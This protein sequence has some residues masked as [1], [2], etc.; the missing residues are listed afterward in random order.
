MPEPGSSTEGNSNPVRQ[1][2]LRRGGQGFG[3]NIVGPSPGESGT[4]RGVFISRLVPTGAAAQSG[5]LM[6]GDQLLAVDGVNVVDFTHSDTA[7][8]LKVRKKTKEEEEGGG[9]GGGEGRRPRRREE[10]Q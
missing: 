6:I 2:T 1:V 7:A 10:E 9:E 5:E 8:L 4:V 3:F